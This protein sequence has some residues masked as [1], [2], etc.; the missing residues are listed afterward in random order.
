MRLLVPR[1]NSRLFP[2]RQQGQ[3]ILLIL[4]VT[5]IGILIGLSLINNGILTSEKIQLQN[6]AD[7]TAYSVSTIEARDLNF[8]SYTN[9]AMVANEVAVGQM[10]GMMSWASMI[11]STPAFLDLYFSPIYA[12]PVIGQVI[13][14]IINAL[15]L[16]TG[17]IKTG[18]KTFTKGGATVLPFFN[19]AYSV[20]QRGMHLATLYFGAMTLFETIDANADDAGMSLFG[21]LVL[22]RHLNTYF[23]DL[24]FNDDSF[25]T[26]YRQSTK[27]NLI[28]Q[29]GGDPESDEQKAGMQ[30]LAA[31]IN[32]S[33]DPF[34]MNRDCK[35]HPI[36][37]SWPCTNSGGWSIPMFPPIKVK[38]NVKVWGVCVLCF[39]IEFSINMKRKGGT[40]LRTKTSKKEEHY[41]WTAVDTLGIV[42]QLKANAKILG[43]QVVPSF[44][45]D[46]RLDIPFGI[47]GA[48][49]APTADQVKAFPLDKTIW[50]DSVGGYTLDGA[51]ASGYGGSPY[52]APISWL[53][54]SPYPGDGG[55]SFAVAK[56]NINTSYP[57]LPR[58]NETKAGPD[59]IKVDNNYK[60]GFEAPYLLIALEKDIDKVSQSSSTGRFQL[61][62]NTALNRLAVI[63]KSEVYFSRPLDL[64]YFARADGNV[65][66]ANAFNP[67]WSARLVD[68]SY[69]DRTSALAMQQQQLW[70]P[71]DITAVLTQ[72]KDL[73]SF[74]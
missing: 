16:V 41:I 11:S 6:A 44:L 8:A 3:A 39:S 7:A 57:G 20:A 55:P 15:K 27:S 13:Q 29:R 46:V 65:E 22:A 74:L 59:P 21:Y 36:F 4:L 34:S 33:R 14:V 32:A 68:T 52:W 71:K 72:L 51:D 47:G 48:Q 37:G 24:S 18:V 40:D 35:A 56:N 25:V 64:S 45:R 69:I 1:N 9:R 28:P 5:V 23:G 54:A 62:P 38:K 60:F 63:G 31:M 49:A 61:D 17:V 42:A 50:G 30:N 53:F 12:V 58:Y 67:Y 73:L 66:L 19:K 26:S 10:V 2:A 70:L 43:V